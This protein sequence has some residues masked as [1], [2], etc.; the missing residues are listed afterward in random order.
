MPPFKLS[1][2]YTKGALSTL[3]P[4]L[5]LQAARL[6]HE[7]R[8]PLADSIVLATAR[9]LEAQLWTQDADFKDKPGVRYRAKR[10]AR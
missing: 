5:A 6:G 1:P 9:Q 2:Y 4:P 8:L 3:D 10:S 7:E